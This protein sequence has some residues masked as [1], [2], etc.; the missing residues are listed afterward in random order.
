MLLINSLLLCR[1]VCSIHSALLSKHLP[2]AAFLTLTI[3]K[4]TRKGY[5]EHS[6]GSLAGQ[7]PPGRSRRHFC[8]ARRTS[9]LGQLCVSSSEA[10]D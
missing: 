3:P 6:V 10:S 7:S 2:K 5:F 1:G 8:T 4:I 9:A